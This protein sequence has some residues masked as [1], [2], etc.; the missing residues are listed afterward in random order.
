[1]DASNLRRQAVDHD[2]EHLFAFWDGLD[3]AD[4]RALLADLGSIDFDLLDTLIE[5]HVR[6]ARPAAAA[7]Q[8]TPP[9][10]LPVEP[11]TPEQAQLYAD[12]RQRGRELIA[13]GKVAAMVVAG[14]Q[15]T[16][17]GFDG[18]KGAFAISPI[19][20]K[21]L[22]QLFAESL[23]ATQRR[24]GAPIRWYVMTSPTND[25]PTRNFL[26]DHAYFGLGPDS[27]FF[28]QQ[29]V[30]PAVDMGGRI[31]LADR[32]RLALAPDGHG[33]SLRALAA[34]G[35]LADMAN[36]SVEIISYFQVDNSLVT[37]IDPL[38]VGLHDL[39]G[40]QM[41]SLTVSKA[42]DDERVG[43]FALVDSKLRVIEYTDLPEKL[44]R[45]RNADGS[46]TFDAANIAVHVLSRAF[47]EELTRPGSS[48]ALPW[49]PAKK[50]VPH[51]DLD[52]GRRVVPEAPNAVKFEMF[53]FD[54]LPLAADPLLLT[55]RRGEVFSPVKNATG[56]DSADTARRDMVR[57]AASWLEQCGVNVP[58]TPN[59]EPDCTLEISPLAALDPEQLRQ[60]LP[61]LPVIP[62][63]A[64]FHLPGT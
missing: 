5:T 47:V 13:G 42:A 56:V 37:P 10:C 4:R 17:L 26:A 7:G 29:G 12:A 44:A 39:T 3:Q 35:A 45:A 61:A 16:R 43:V 27:V 60:T 28:F 62:P 11:A 23:L 58:R 8:L 1:M 48:L 51:V 50:A 41:S 33:G 15:G 6:A 21:T 63:G 24:F 59:G 9:Q 32:H 34:S 49:H 46:R 55:A 52:T 31:L 18:P 36:H 64:D 19:R 22:F 40:S 54:A 2:Q 30:M 53:V 38:F 14:G 25:R 57:R 20:H